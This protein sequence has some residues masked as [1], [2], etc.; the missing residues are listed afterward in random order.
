MNFVAVADETISFWKD[1]KISPEDAWFSLTGERRQYVNWSHIE[2]FMI[3]WQQG[4]ERRRQQTIR[5]IA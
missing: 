5:R 4:E 2:E 3:G 1:Q